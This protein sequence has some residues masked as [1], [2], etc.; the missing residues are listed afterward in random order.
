MRIRKMFL[1]IG[2]TLLCCTGA[3]GAFPYLDNDQDVDGL[4]LVLAINEIVVSG[5]VNK[6]A[7]WPTALAVLPARKDFN[8]RSLLQFF[9]PRT[10][11]WEW[12]IWIMTV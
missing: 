3:H 8:I 1:V 2:A 7:I 11:R 12:G 9:P 4:D 10:E 6:L 5:E